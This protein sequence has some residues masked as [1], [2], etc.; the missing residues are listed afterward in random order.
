ME[1]KTESS[2]VPAPQQLNL[3]SV[4]S[5]TSV[6][7]ETE[8][9]PLT[10]RA[11]NELYSCI[12]L[13]DYENF[14]RSP[15]PALLALPSVV[16]PTQKQGKK[17]KAKKI[18]ES[19]SEEEDEAGEACNFCNELFIDSKGKEGWI[20]RSGC[21]GWAHEAC[22]N[23]EEEEESFECDF[24]KIVSVRHQGQIFNTG[25]GIQIHLYYVVG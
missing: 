5:S 4:T 24:C 9:L 8:P 17:F 1:K 22:S 14:L 21:S 13:T 25:Q 18:T 16:I 20:Q 7:T 10:S 12:P 6:I 15:P 11:S 2:S 23:T 3:I 19:S